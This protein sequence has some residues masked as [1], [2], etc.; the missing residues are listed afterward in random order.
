MSQFDLCKD[1]RWYFNVLV[2]S[3][4]RF[5]YLKELAMTKLRSSDIILHPK[6]IKWAIEYLNKD[7]K[8]ELLK[9]KKLKESH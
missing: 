3:F 7:Y 4:P 2:G 8:V 9:S 1:V 6:D 5:I